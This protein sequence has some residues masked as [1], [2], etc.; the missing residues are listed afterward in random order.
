MKRYKPAEDPAAVDST[1]LGIVGLYHM[2]AK[3][4]LSQPDVS[5]SN[6]TMD[7]VGTIAQVPGK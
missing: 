1:T 7:V 4:P 5:Q 6:L 2:D 3:P